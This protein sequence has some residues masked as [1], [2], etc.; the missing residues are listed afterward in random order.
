[1]PGAIGPP[2]KDKAP[3][4]QS[5]ARARQD[6][7]PGKPLSRPCSSLHLLD[8]VSQSLLRYILR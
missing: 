6:R 2:G 3:A 7:N 4:Q 5:A 1:V 8:H